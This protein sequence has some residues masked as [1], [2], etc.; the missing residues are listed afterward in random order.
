MKPSNQ[1]ISSYSYTPPAFVTEAQAKPNKPVYDVAKYPESSNM[2]MCH[3]E[4]MD[5]FQ[6]GRSAI[7]AWRKNRNFPDPISKAPLRWIRA[8]VMEWVEHQ[9]GFKASI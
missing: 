9:G 4:V 8:A 6:K 3:H 5:Y 7:F 2:L 1:T